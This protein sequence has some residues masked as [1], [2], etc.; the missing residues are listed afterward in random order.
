MGIDEKE[1]EGFSIREYGRYAK[2][3]ALVAAPSPGGFM[4]ANSRL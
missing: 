2:R 3:L 1:G 4:R